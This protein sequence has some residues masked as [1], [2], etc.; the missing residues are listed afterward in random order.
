M[1]ACKHLSAAFVSAFVCI[2]AAQPAVAQDTKVTEGGYS[3]FHETMVDMTSQEVEEAAKRGAILLWPLGV[4]EEHGPQLPLGTDIY[5]A[6]ATMKQTAR[7]LKAKG[8]EVLIAPPMY[9]GIN[10]ATGAFAGSFNVRPSTLKA[11]IEDT[12]ASFRKDGFQV[13]YM[14]TGHGD[15]L[16]NQVIVEGVEAARSITGMRGFVALPTVMKDRLGLKG[17]E[18]HVVL[19]ESP[20]VFAKP[21]R[22]IEVHAG[23]GET[24]NV[25]FNFP[26]LVKAEL[27]PTLPDTKLGPDDLAEWRKGWDNARTKTPLGY[28]GDPASANAQ[29]GEQM[30]H[31]GASRLTD[32]IEK[33]LQSSASWLKPGQR[34]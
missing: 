34:R 27:I 20:P 22:F 3:V 5:N 11:I 9:W 29:V 10:D 31:G 14:I 1:K 2:V 30:F 15:R 8:R 4:I 32:A 16:H 18:A 24:S 25:W 17:N 6:Y 28:F 21:P 7:L 33:H 12:F 19:I 13:V 23:A 26:L